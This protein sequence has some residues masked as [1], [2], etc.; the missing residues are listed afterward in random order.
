MFLAN[1]TPL[2]LPERVPVMVTTK[3]SVWHLKCRKHPSSGHWFRSFSSRMGYSF[4]HLIND[5]DW[6]HRQRPGPLLESLM[7]TDKFSIKSRI[8]QLTIITNQSHYNLQV[9]EISTSS[10][11]IYWQRFCLFFYNYIHESPE[12]KSSTSLLSQT[13]RNCCVWTKISFE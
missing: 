1:C 11:F 3:I 13:E 8:L 5:P 7:D 6:H 12:N 9:I 10:I 2:W 4:H